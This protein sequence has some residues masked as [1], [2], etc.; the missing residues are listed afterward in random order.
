MI[1]AIQTAACGHMLEN[2]ISTKQILTRGEHNI[3]RSRIS[4]NALKVLYRLKNAGFEG[5]LVGGG[6]RDLLLE[7]TPKDFDVSTDA[8]PEQV[9]DLFRNCR[10]IGRRFRLAHVHFGQEIIEVATFR[11][12]Q[13]SEEPHE[14]REIVDGM[15]VRDN[16]FGSMEEDAWRRDFTI[17]SL[18]YNIQDFSVVDYVGGVQDLR[19]RRIR[20]IGDPELRYRE[21]PVRMLRAIRFAAKLGFHIE[22]ETEEWLYKLQSLL[23]G[24]PPARLFEEVI[25]LFLSGHGENTFLLARKYGMYVQLFP[26]TDECLE[27]DDDGIMHRFV[28]KALQNTDLRVQEGKPVTPSFIFA[29]FLW[30]PISRLKARYLERGMSESQAIFAASDAVLSGQSLRV[31]IPRRFHSAVREIWQLQDR[32]AKPAPKRSLRL[33]KHPR[34]RAAYDFMLLRAD[35]GDVDAE[36]ASWW[37]NFHDANEESREKM[38]SGLDKGR[39]R[40]KRRRRS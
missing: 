11:G 28:I 29:V 34:F 2:Q 23:E 38:L 33:L 4:E 24:V 37:V 16:V 15:I 9:K 10:L 19:E 8:T 31:A 5:F 30:G 21:D 14:E 32:L 1:A 6:V 20:I 12:G 26:Q 39:R 7:R 40:R 36:L 18:F 35:A 17:N 13:D 22:G 3:S 25:K 27:T